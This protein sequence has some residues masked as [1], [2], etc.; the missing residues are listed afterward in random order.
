MRNKKD[1]FILLLYDPQFILRYA[2]VLQTVN[3]GNV[4]T[5]TAVIVQRIYDIILLYLCSSFPSKIR[6][7]D[8]LF[9]ETYRETE[10]KAALLI[11]RYLCRVVCSEFVRSRKAILGV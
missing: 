10:G 5:I 4:I 11:V 9:E 1:F 3:W 7:A 6:I 2:Y 8:M